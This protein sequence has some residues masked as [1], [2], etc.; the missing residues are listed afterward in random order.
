MCWFYLS[1]SEANTCL[2]IRDARNA[3]DLLEERVGEREED[4]SFVGRFIRVS[5]GRFQTLE[6]LA[7][8]FGNRM[9]GLAQSS[10]HCSSPPAA[11]PSVPASRASSVESQVSLGAVGGSSAGSGSGSPTIAVEVEIAD[12][13]NEYPLMVPYWGTVIHRR[14]GL[15]WNLGEY[16]A[17]VERVL[18]F[19]AEQAENEAI[20]WSITHPMREPSLEGSRPPTPY[21]GTW[22]KFE[23]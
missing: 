5:E 6:N 2:Q 14:P 18:D 4:G 22:S 8:E 19:Q 23:A 16:Q 15:G 21:E 10:C 17:E 12:E 11:V 1:V 20:A 9:E 3:F 13:E 7:E